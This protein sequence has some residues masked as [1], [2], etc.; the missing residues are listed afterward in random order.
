MFTCILI[1]LDNVWCG[2]M[3]IRGQVPAE[4]VYLTVPIAESNW[5]QLKGF[6]SVCQWSFVLLLLTERPS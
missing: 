4:H 5:M 3:C 2:E 6:C 1:L